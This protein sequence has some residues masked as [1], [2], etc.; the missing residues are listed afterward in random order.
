M[1]LTYCRMECQQPCDR[2][3]MASPRPR[4]LAAAS[5]TLGRGRLAGLGSRRALRWA[6]MSRGGG[7]SIGI[8]RARLRVG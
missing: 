2:E 8:H 3:Q 6:D 4:P 1:P 5:K 7:S